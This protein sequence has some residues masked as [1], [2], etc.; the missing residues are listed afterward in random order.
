MASITQQRLIGSFLL[1]C[2]LGAVAFFLINSASNDVE[3]IPNTEPDI[4]FVSSIDAISE[5]NINIVDVDQE[6]LIDAQEPEIDT[7]SKT[8][9]QQK[10]DLKPTQKTPE[11]KPIS[12]PQAEKPIANITMWSLQ[13]ASLADHTAATALSDKVNK[14]GYKA[15]VE[16]AETSKGDRFRVRI[17]PEQNKAVLEKISKTLE[18]ELK[19]RP[20]LL[21]Q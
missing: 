5:E 2:V 4:P 17:G 8:D 10:L 18:K 15:S 13:I 7:Q 14:L 9:H 1:L 6:A 11:T 12:E 3:T 20:L 21:K 16:K 19:L